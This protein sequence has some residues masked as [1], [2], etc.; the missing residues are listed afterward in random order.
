MDARWNVSFTRILVAGS[1][2][3]TFVTSS[4]GEFDPRS[5][6]VVEEVVVVGKQPGPKL[7]RV[8]SGDRELWVL[9]VLSPLPKK[10]QWDSESVEAVLADTEEVIEPPGLTISANPVKLLFVMP[11]LWGIQNN[12]QKKEL[13]DIL[14]ADLYHRWSVLRE[15]YMGSGLKIEKKRPIFAATEL[16]QE[17][18]DQSGMANSGMVYQAIEKSVKKYKIPRTSTSVTRRLTSPRSVV[19]DIKES[20]IDDIECFQRTI[21]RLEVDLGAMRSRASAWASGDMAA[22]KALPYEDQN[23]ACIDAVLNSSVATQ[24]AESLELVDIEAQ[25]KAK[26][27][28]AAE[29]ALQNNQVTFATLPIEELLKPDGYISSL[30]AKGYEVRGE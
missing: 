2:L 22:L 15:R 25:M 21:E 14:P 29:K 17:A 20:S 6:R 24:L 26:W 16:F 4:A 13:K 3:I 5:D 8:S 30:K 23:V 12:P 10:L 1:C 27:L 9:G 28:Q 18:L 11:S 7:W 19:K